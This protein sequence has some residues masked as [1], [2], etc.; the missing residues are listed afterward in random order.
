M[1]V[2]T[3]PH[4]LLI[5]HGKNWNR[6][7]FTPSVPIELS[8]ASKLNALAAARAYDLNLAKTILFSTGK[9]A[10]DKAPS[11]AR[12]MFEY[13][14]GTGHAIPEFSAR[15]QEISF[16][17]ETEAEENIKIIEQQKAKNIA[18]LSVADHIPR[19][20]DIYTAK[21]IQV[22]GYS[23]E[24]L[25]SGLGPYYAQKVRRYERSLNRQLIKAQEFVLQMD[26]EIGTKGKLPTWLARH[27]R[28]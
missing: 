7:H 11:E 15:L 13:L 6:H 3:G 26:R 20:V 14:G 23:A 19:V 12:A 10:R 9:T 1:T 5:V 2:E 8:E 22:T 17:T 4:D 27:L 21:G 25:A 28:G 16:D 24:E 18:V